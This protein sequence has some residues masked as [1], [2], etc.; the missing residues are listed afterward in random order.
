MSAYFHRRLNFADRNST[1]LVSS[2]RV[3][4]SA[5]FMVRC[6]FAGVRHSSGRKELLFG[7]AK[8]IVLMATAENLKEVL[9]KSS[10]RVGLV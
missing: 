1:P 4:G 7:I 5:F 8:T 6:H 3:P 10:S 2:S 9:T